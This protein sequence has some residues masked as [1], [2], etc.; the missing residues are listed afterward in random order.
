MYFVEAYLYE[1]ESAL[2]E[3][4]LKAYLRGRSRAQNTQ[5]T[6]VSVRGRVASVKMQLPIDD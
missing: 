1:R 6:G 3:S 5:T 4:A 2:D